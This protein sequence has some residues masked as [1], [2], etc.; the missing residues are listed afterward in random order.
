MFTWCANGFTNTHVEHIEHTDASID[1]CYLL[2]LGKAERCATV[3]KLIRTVFGIDS[4]RLSSMT[5]HAKRLLCWFHSHMRL[6][7]VVVANVTE[8]FLWQHWRLLFATKLTEKWEKSTKFIVQST[9]FDRC[10]SIWTGNVG[11]ILSSIH[12]KWKHVRQIPTHFKLTFDRRLTA[13][14][15]AIQFWDHFLLQKHDKRTVNKKMS[16]LRLHSMW[17][18]SNGFSLNPI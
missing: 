17:S 16:R 14:S 8:L 5:V 7:V 4:I 18:L 3:T 1:V 13:D 2:S 10:K 6:G 12:L 9:H 11:V 15:F